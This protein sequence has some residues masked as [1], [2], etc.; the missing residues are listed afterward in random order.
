MKK[1]HAGGSLK[2]LCLAAMALAPAAALAEEVRLTLRNGGS[3]CGV[4][5]SEAGG[6]V[7]LMTPQGSRAL[8]SREIA[9]RRAEDCGGGQAGTSAQNRGA[10]QAAGAPA[11]AQQTVPAPARPA[12]NQL[13]AGRELKL[14]GAADIGELLVPDLV[15]GYLA[16]L[17]L[18]P[19]GWSQGA[20]PEQRFQEGRDGRGQTQRRL[21]VERSG[22]G[23]AFVALG[24]RRADIAMSTRAPSEAEASQVQRAL[25][26]DLVTPQNEHVLALDGLAVIVHPD[27]PVQRL[28]LDQIRDI[29]AGAITNWNAVGGP[30]RPIR[31]LASEATAG[32]T[33]QFT[34][35]VMRERQI[36]GNAER[37]TSSAQ[38]S[39]TVAAEPSA[40][41][42][43]G[44]SYVGRARALNL[45]ASC[46]IEFPAGTFEVKTQDYPLERRLYLYAAAKDNPMAEDFL[47][48][49]ASPA[50][51]EVVTDAGYISLQPVVSTREYTQ[52]RLLDATR[53]APT[54]P[55]P[56]YTQAMADYSLAVRQALRLSSTFRFDEGSQTVDVLGQGE[57]ERVAE[58]MKR[59][60]NAKYKVSVLGFSDNIG[61]FGQQRSVSD[62]RAQEV[63]RQLRQRG[64]TVNHVAGYG[65]VA[66]VACEEDAS[67]PAKNRRVELW[68][69]Q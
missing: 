28:K 2:G 15:D 69:T 57:L 43:V 21:T 33:E 10:T 61:A 13:P 31:V 20:T 56:R 36:A 51:T 45:V 65:Y 18:R 55:D 37:V 12:A 17:G 14:V 11:G 29:F 23:D 42:L 50:G 27:N 16:G 52:F 53:A 58:F 47:R 62:R 26:V 54:A 3:A 60:E 44:M 5:T 48:Y 64:V 39:N 6:M 35:E 40:I 19:R 24:E 68:L 4:I 38:I 41:G 30:N 34:A 9:T 7:T 59:P 25:G 66:P 49:V 1:R 22:P 8:P 32:S 63:A 46:G 67:A